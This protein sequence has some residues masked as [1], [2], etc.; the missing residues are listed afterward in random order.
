MINRLKELLGK[1]EQ[2]PQFSDEQ[3]EQHYELK[4]QGLERVLGEMYHLVGHAIIPFQV[5]GAVDMYYF[6]RA[7]DGTAFATMELIEPDG[8]GPQPSRIGTYELVAFTKYKIGEAAFEKIERRMCRIFTIVA[9][10]SYEAQLNPLET[11]EVPAG[12]DEPNYCLILDEYKKQGVEFIIGNS[13]HGLLLLIEVFRS[14]MEYAMK[15]GSQVV[16]DKLRENGHY[17]YSD[18]GREPVF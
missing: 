12:E 4:K 15:H 14:E 18:L 16:L 7:V 3:Y 5:G 9:R 1:K 2:T 8:S 6:P 17:P 11:I 10:Y 13:R